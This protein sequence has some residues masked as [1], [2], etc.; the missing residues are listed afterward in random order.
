M[1]AMVNRTVG[2]CGMRLADGTAW[3]PRAVKKRV[4]APR[5]S[6]ASIGERLPG[7]RWTTRRRR[8]PAWRPRRPSRRGAGRSGG[9]GLASG[10]ASSPHSSASRRSRARRPSSTAPRRRAAT[11]PA[12]ARAC[13]AACSGSAAPRPAARSGAPGARPTASPRCRAPPRPPAT[14]DGASLRRPSRATPAVGPAGAGAA[15]PFAPG[16]R[17]ATSGDRIER[18]P[19]AAPAR[20]AITLTTG[21]AKAR[22]ARREADSTVAVTDSVSSSTAPTRAIS[23]EAWS[24]ARRASVT[25]GTASPRSASMPR[26]RRRTWPTRMAAAATQTTAATAATTAAMSTTT[27]AADI[28]GGYRLGPAGGV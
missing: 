8:L 6:V 28:P 11:A 12:R 26:S 23:S 3:C 22:W 2:S 13:C 9:A 14:P 21:L 1:P 15:P 4:K 10:G 25:S 5:S 17:G 27:S 7:R 19:L 20:K 16:G 24:T 18:S